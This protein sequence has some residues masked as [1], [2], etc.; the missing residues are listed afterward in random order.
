MLGIRFR[1]SAR[2]ARPENFDQRRGQGGGLRCGGTPLG[3]LATA[4]ARRQAGGYL[5]GWAIKLPWPRW[6]RPRRPCRNPN[7]L[8]LRR[9]MAARMAPPPTQGWGLAERGAGCWAVDGCRQDACVTGR[10]NPFLCRQ[11]ACVTGCPNLFCCRQD[12]CATGY[13]KRG[14]AAFTVGT[15][16]PAEQSPGWGLAERVRRRPVT[17]TFQRC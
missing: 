13:G 12:A 3:R 1:H 15:V 17:E 11:D 10:P 9:R 6:T 14:D 16:R 5:G 2:S 4:V 7:W 8:L